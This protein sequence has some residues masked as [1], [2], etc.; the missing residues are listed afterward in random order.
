MPDNFKILFDTV[1]KEYDLGTAEQFARRMGTPENRLQFFQS[2]G[3]EYDLG[4]FG[5]FET[6][7]GKRQAKVKA[8]AKAEAEQEKPGF[9]K[10]TG[11]S[12]LENIATNYGMGNPTQANPLLQANLTKY[13]TGGYERPESKGFGEGAAEFIGGAAADLPMM[14][15]AGGL[16]GGVVKKLGLGGMKGL[17]AR[18]AGSAFGATRPA[19]NIKERALHSLE[20]AAVWMG[21][22]V[23]GKGVSKGFKALKLKIRSG[24]ELSNA[25]KAAIVAMEKTNAEIGDLTQEEISQRATEIR[26]LLPAHP[27]T[28]PES[29]ENI[30]NKKL[31]ETAKRLN[32]PELHRT[33]VPKSSGYLADEVNEALIKAGKLHGESKITV[34]GGEYGKASRQ[35]LG[36]LQRVGEEIEPGVSEKVAGVEAAQADRMVEK[37]RG[38]A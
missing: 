1:G 4:T 35:G 2:V 20:D 6:R 29:M 16:G 37:V 19:E 23:V 7:I 3:K 22:G 13:L 5:E 30:S 15:G 14:I 38:A 17:L 9:L 34:S 28:L 21:F 18:E 8:E 27:I 32:I 25:E 24:V 11:L 36:G 31:L 10:R 26:G 33:G 12:L